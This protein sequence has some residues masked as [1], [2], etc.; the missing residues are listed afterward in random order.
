MARSKS[1]YACMLN[2]AGKFTDD[3]VIYR[4]STISWMV[5]HGSGSGHEE[6]TRASI[7]RDVSVRFDDN[8]HGVS[9]HPVPA[10]VHPVAEGIVERQQRF[11]G[12]AVGLVGLLPVRLPLSHLVLG[13]R[14]VGNRKIACHRPYLPC[15]G[16]L[17]CRPRASLPVSA[18]DPTCAPRAR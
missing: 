18:T 17:L 5:V 7:G 8:L 2:D 16:V 10:P 9:H 14:K 3:C 13:N 12:V 15:C 6:L 4:I 1:V 11:Q